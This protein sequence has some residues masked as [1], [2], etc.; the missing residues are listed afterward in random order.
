MNK[1]SLKIQKTKTK[2]ELN[3]TV[4]LLPCAAQSS[5]IFIST[6]A[7]AKKMKLSDEVKCFMPSGHVFVHELWIYI[8]Q[9]RNNNSELRSLKLRKFSILSCCRKRNFVMQINDNFIS[10]LKTKIFFPY[11]FSSALPG[12]LLR[13]EKLVTQVIEYSLPFVTPIFV[14]VFHLFLHCSVQFCWYS[15]P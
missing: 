1:T 3:I 8:F 11:F 14:L 15:T 6:T 5:V 7:K 9:S 12:M 10:L 2:V 13:A 4:F